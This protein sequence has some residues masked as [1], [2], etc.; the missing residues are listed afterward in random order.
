MAKDHTNDKR[1][2]YQTIAG[3]RFGRWLALH[4]IENAGRTRYWQ[5]RCDCG[6]ERGVAMYSLIHGGTQSCGCLVKEFCRASFTTHKAT[7]GGEH[8][9]EY[10]VWAG[11]RSRCASTKDS[12]YGGRGIK[13]CDRWNSF[14][15]FL[16]D[17]GRRPSQ[18]HSIERID[19]AGNYEPTNCRWATRKEQGR[20][21]RNNILLTYNGET[22][23]AVEWSEI[24]GIPAG[25]IR[26]WFKRG[27]SHER[28]LGT[29]P[30]EY[31]KKQSHRVHI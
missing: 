22:K 11:I 13:V 14:E 3:M 20:N 18:D 6:T 23:T 7:V 1:F 26:K 2:K 19:N 31:R 30:H 29:P 16:E 24:T 15:L 9:A 12:R 8:Q 21:K 25:T 27:W 28:I 10:V 17:M 5:C 4:E